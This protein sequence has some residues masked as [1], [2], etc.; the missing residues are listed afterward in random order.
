MS[1]LRHAARAATGAALLIAARLQGQNPTAPPAAAPP[2]SS[3]S[4][5]TAGMA[6]QEGFVPIYLDNRTDRLLLEIPR[7]STRVLFFVTQ[8]TG[9]GS[10]PVGIDRGANGMDQVARFDR[11]GDRVL[12]VFENWNY[13]SVSDNAAHQRTVAEAF[14]PSTVASL[15]L[16]AEEGGRLLVDATDLLFRDWL[17]V[18][19]TLAG[20]GQGNYVVQR[21]RS[22]IYRPYTKSLPVNTELD[23]SL[24]F[25]AQG[26]PGRIVGS[27]APD[28]RAITMRQHV[29]L[30]P[31]PDGGFQPREQ[32][33]RVGYFGIS[34][35]DYA[36]PLQRPLQQEW[37]SRHR[38]ERVNPADP[39]S[40]IK[41]PI[42]YY[43]DRG[44]PEP[45]RT[46]TL[47][48]VKFWEQAFD[49]AGLVGGFKVELLPE[50]VDPMD[51]RY[52]VVQ[53]VNRNERGWSIGGS[54]G[55]P[56]TGE[57]I[58]AMARMDSHRNRTD[59]NIYAALMGAD[60]AAAD[61]AYVLSRIRQVSS[62]EV[63][64]TLGLSH[65]YIASSYERGSVM[66]YPAPRVRLDANGNIDLSKAYDVGPGAY[67]VWAI[68]WGY[69]IFPAAQEQDSLRAIVADGLKRGFLYLSDAD[70]RPEFA[71]DPRTT[72][73]DDAA[74]PTEFLRH[75]MAVRKVALA[76]FGE[77]NIRPGDPIA[78]LQ[79]RL[80][81][82]YFFHR[83]ALNGTAKTIGGMEYTQPV[84]GDMQQA[85][86][87][88][89]GTRQREAIR[90]LSEALQP[91]AL[92]I[93]DSVLSL[94][95]P[96][97]S[98]VTNGVE[99]F[100][101]RTRPSFDELGAARTLSQMIVDMMLQPAR[102]A[103]V[104]Q[105]ETRLAGA[106]RIT[107]SEVMDAPVAATWGRA[108]PA[109]AKFAALQRAAQRSVADRLILLAADSLAAPEVRAMADLKLSRLMVDAGGRARAAGT[110][111]AKAHWMTMATDIRQ[112]VEKREVP[113]LTAA[114]VA[115]PGDPF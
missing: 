114:L 5:R 87:P 74:T 71:S 52:N 45:L 108:V 35:K 69:G 75:Q 18:A 95:V 81:P 33:S 26:R 6:K 20:G 106:E 97:A 102:M 109:S 39:R 67:D 22:T 28:G 32:D 13:R 65:N 104:A 78:L 98:S 9:L 59:Y 14:P 84:R 57:I 43:V 37:I 11:A 85:T 42:R 55:D 86:R 36:Q 88:V 50:G 61:T 64:H 111:A 30:L 105:F 94:M 99:L 54:L 21:D 31:L 44:I 93:P 92:A 62:H 40:P 68:H 63:G 3:I 12:L 1:R 96:N 103:R 77:R 91:E 58:K 15:P 2:A 41:N 113:K 107:L 110:D 82:L 101:T 90:M 80:A 112:W 83:F 38:L 17:D 72:L 27:I 56:R 46:A 66:D 7:D 23:A 47:Q 34:F 73:W 29:S 76:K 16:V 10:N 19:G 51:A 4:A 115:P 100:G 70:A 49:K 24:T 79:E 53:W 25:V 89:S 48:G 60:A 8:A